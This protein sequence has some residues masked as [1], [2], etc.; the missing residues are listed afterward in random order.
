MK[1]VEALLV[2]RTDSIRKAMEILEHSGSTI[3]LLVDSSGRLERTVTDGDLR[4][5]LMKGASLDASLSSLPALHPTTT[6]DGDSAQ[7]A[8][9]AMNLHQVDQLPVVDAENRP[10]SVFLRREVD[11]QILL[12]S[13]HM[14]DEEISFIEAAFRSNWIAPLGPNVDAFEAELA[15]HVG[16]AAAA[17]VSSGTAAI[18][19]ALRLLDVGPADKVFCSTLTFVATANPILYQGAQPVFIDADRTSWNMSVPA[20][21]RAMEAHAQAGSLPKAVIVVNL[22][23]QSADMDAITEVCDRFRVP[24]IED[25]AESLGAYYRGQSSGTFGRLGIYSFNGNK[26]ITTSGGGMLVSQEPALMERARFFATQARD[27][28]PFYQHTEVGY[29]YRM[30]NVLAG[31]GRGQLRVLKERV[32]QRRAIFERYLNGCSAIPALEW[33]PEAVKCRSTRWLS[34]ATISANSGVTPATLIGHLRSQQIEARHVWKPLHLQ[35]LFAG[36]DYFPH[37]AGESISEDL[38]ARGICL[39]SGSN[40]SID[41]QNRIIRSLHE[42]FRRA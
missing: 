40:M 24:I 33:M 31:I 29:N 32:E 23:G 18:H 7:L 12:S 41:Q 9:E 5:L 16:I 8:L 27:P 17:A 34:T 14:G 37:R 15:A 4:R 3:L 6:R 22:Y 20:L 38:F 11:P 42:F 25:A 39:P 26:I 35:P 21:T 19:L 10:I 13:P 30:S 36:C 1:N 28:A 2:T